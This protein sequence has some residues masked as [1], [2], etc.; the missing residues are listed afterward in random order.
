[1]TRTP[2]AEVR[3]QL[4]AE[5]GFV[6]PVPD[7]TNPYLT[8]HHF[9]PPWHIC[10]HQNPIGMIALC[11]DH[12]AQADNGA[13]EV[14]QLRQLKLT[15][16]AKATNQ[17]IAGV[18]N[19]RRQRLLAVVGGNFLLDCLQLVWYRNEASI[20]L[21]DDSE[22]LLALNVRMPT[23][24]SERRLQ[25]EENCWMCSGVPDDLECP[26]AGNLIR[27]KYPN[28]DQLSVRFS[29]CE[30]AGVFAA[31]FPK[32]SGCLWTAEVPFPITI[33]EITGTVGGTSLRYSPT[34]VAL[35]RDERAQANFIAETDFPALRFI[36]AE[37]QLSPFM[38][39]AMKFVLSPSVPSI[40]LSADL[41]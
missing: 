27:I 31:R 5:V 21:T 32:T 6:C 39:A 13:F 40:R 23:I 26:P 11:R 20:W 36:R 30:S 12:H 1:M 4:R 29:N 16:K 9:D 3:R 10:Q 37:D 33:V 41:D 28:D 15:G 34:A 19:W 8:W 14:D 17:M 25:I 24:S 18:F 2:K 7:C 22:N 35:G 38:P